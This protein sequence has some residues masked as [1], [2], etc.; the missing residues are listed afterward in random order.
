MEQTKISL[1]FKLPKTININD[2]ITVDKVSLKGD[3]LNVELTIQEAFQ[4]RDFCTLE[5]GSIFIFKSLSSTPSET[6][7]YYV[8]WSSKNKDIFMGDLFPGEFG[9]FDTVKCRKSTPEEIEFF[10]KQLQEF[11]FIW[12]PKLRKLEKFFPKDSIIKYS[13]SPEEDF[14]YFLKDDLVESKGEFEA[15]A[16]IN[17]LTGSVIIVPDNDYI[18]DSNIISGLKLASPSEINFFFREIKSTCN[19]TWDPERKEFRFKPEMDE[20]YYF[21]EDDFEIMYRHYR[22]VN[23]FTGQQHYKHYNMFKTRQDA[24]DV[25]RKLLK[26]LK[27]PKY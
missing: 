16:A 21:I 8:G 7:P 9:S 23:D 2:H 11:N 6:I 18:L 14:L 27:Y 26:I 12:N 15:Y 22:G 1:D 25:K 20:Q 4:D 17:T 3:N 10:N 19:L 5:D 13:I 24:L